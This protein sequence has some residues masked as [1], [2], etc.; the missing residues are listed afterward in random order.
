MA[1]VFAALALVLLTL[2]LNRPLAILPM[3][4]L[5][6]ILASAAVDLMDLKTL[7][8]IRR[9]SRIEL[10]LGLITAIG[11]VGLGVMNGIMIAV[12][13]SI[14]HLLWYA[15]APSDAL[16]GQIR[17]RPGL[18]NLAQHANAEPIPGILIYRFE[19]SPL[20]L[21]AAWFRQ[22]ALLA[23]AQYP[24]PFRLFLLDARVMVTIDSTAQDEIIALADLL[25]QQDTRLVL[26]GG[27]ERFREIVHRG[28]LAEALGPENVY[29]TVST[30]LYALGQSGAAISVDDSND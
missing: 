5:G 7:W 19:G 28:G 20:F 27:S 29:E 16:L 26:A 9:V 22:R 4:A 15:S 11:V 6:A 23:A 17:G 18:Y 8:R 13:A 10:L 3:A 2:V 21:N 12:G 25:R 30:A 1:A 24:H 14:V